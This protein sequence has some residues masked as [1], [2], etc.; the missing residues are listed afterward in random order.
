MV[1]SAP[2]LEAPKKAPTNLH[3][4][5]V[6]RLRRPNDPQSDPQG[7]PK[8]GPNPSKIIT[9]SS[10]SRRGRPPATFDLNKW[11]W[12]GVPPK[13]YRTYTEK[14][15]KDS[16]CGISAEYRYQ[17]LLQNV[18]KKKVGVPSSISYFFGCRKSD[19]VQRASNVTSLA[20]RAYLSGNITSSAA[21]CGEA[22]LD[23]GNIWCIHSFVI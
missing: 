4:R 22:A 15:K 19:W 6:W 5:F 17:L 3:K 9:K 20:L 12:R 10:L 18:F 8:G 14:R 2:F 23:K 11:S 16:L 21:V 7:S 1:V 13:I